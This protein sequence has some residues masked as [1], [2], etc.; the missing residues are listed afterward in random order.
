MD[1]DSKAPIG[2]NTQSI[3]P[4][5]SGHVCL[6]INTNADMGMEQGQPRLS[7]DHVEQVG[8]TSHAFKVSSVSI[9]QGPRTSADAY[10]L[11]TPGHL[12][13]VRQYRPDLL[14]ILPALCRTK[15]ESSCTKRP[16]RL[17]QHETWAFCKEYERQVYD[18]ILE[19][20][21]PA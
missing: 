18:K 17:K 9:L 21:E 11:R 10:G 12:R 20:K 6:A 3:V 1:L 13:R 14:C 15:S 16:L 7:E 19:S 2:D 8:R 5:P 4:D